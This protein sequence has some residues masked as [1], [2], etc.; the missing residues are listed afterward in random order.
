[1]S[2]DLAVVDTSR[3][4]ALQEGGAVAEALAANA[5][6]GESFNDLLTRVKMPSGGTTQFIV[7]TISGEEM[8]KSITGILAGYVC[9]GVIWPSETPVQG[10]Q[11]AFV[12]FDLQTAEAKGGATEE[13][14]QLADPYILRDGRYD[15]QKMTGD[16]APFGWGTSKNGKGKRAKEQRVLF[17]LTDIDPMPLVVSCGPGSLKNVRTFMSNLGKAGV[18]HYRAVVKLTLEKATAT[19]GEPFA[20]VVLT[21][22]GTLT[23]EEGQRIKVGFTDTLHAQARAMAVD[24]DEEE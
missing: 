7:P 16:R 15:W 20:K 14:L 18:P 12:T 22:D 17:L 8:H 21:L 9:R 1:M 5:A 24:A 3:F 4:L 13:L 2:T 23:S 6:T 19:S 10:A 11:P